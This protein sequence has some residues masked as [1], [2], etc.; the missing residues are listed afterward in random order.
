MSRTGASEAPSSQPPS[1]NAVTRDSQEVVDSEGSSSEESLEPDIAVARDGVEEGQPGA[2]DN[3]SMNRMSRF[4]GMG[5]ARF[6]I[7][8][9]LMFAAAAASY[10]SWQAQQAQHLEGVRAE[11]LSAAQTRVPVL[12]SYQASRIDDDLTRAIEQTVGSFRDDYSQVLNEVVAPTAK[13]RGISTQAEVTAAGVVS[14]ETDRV[15]VLV[16]LTQTTT[17]RGQRSTVSGSRVEVTMEPSGANW[18]ISGLEP[19]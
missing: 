3:T 5:W 2:D 4:R 9:A 12:L 14:A 18:K 13:E 10:S 11:A 1:D 6:A 8:L 17:A 16:F 7:A 15:T 19:K